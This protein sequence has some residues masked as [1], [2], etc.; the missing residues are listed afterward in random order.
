MLPG[1]DES[2]IIPPNLFDGK[3]PVLLVEVP[4][5]EMKLNKKISLK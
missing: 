5:Y 2:V 1:D 4:N 3:K